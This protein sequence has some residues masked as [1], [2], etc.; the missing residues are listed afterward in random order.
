[1]PMEE[2]V[3]DD[4][5]AVWSAGLPQE[6]PVDGLADT[7]GQHPPVDLNGHAVDEQNDA[8]NGSMSAVGEGAQEG[9]PQKSQSGGHGGRGYKP[10]EPKVL[11]SSL[12]VSLSCLASVDNWCC[13]T[14]IACSP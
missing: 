3:P 13:R 5:M 11:V 8:Q 2:H 4:Q 6:E 7:S 10:R 14:R 9:S 1:M 12:S